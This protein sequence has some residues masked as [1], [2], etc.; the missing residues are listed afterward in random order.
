MSMWKDEQSAAHYNSLAENVNNV[1][2]KDASADLKDHIQNSDFIVQVSLAADA[3]NTTG[4]TKANNLPLQ[5]S[6]HDLLGHTP[7]ADNDEFEGS[8]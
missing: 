3:V 2:N 6:A 4:N 7:R 1:Q 8:V 5:L